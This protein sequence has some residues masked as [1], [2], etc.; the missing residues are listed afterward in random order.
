MTA[1]FKPS[2]LSGKAGAP[3]SK[4][5][6]HRLLLLS[7]LSGGK[8]LIK[9]LGTSEDVSAMT[10]CLTALGAKITRNG[11]ETTVDSAGF[12][13]TV[14][15]SLYCRESGN[16]L[17][18]LIPLCLT[19]EKTVSLRGSKRLMERPQSVYREL[20][21]KEGFMYN[22]DG[23]S[24]TVR[25]SLKPGKYALD[26]S[27]SSQFI[28][29]MIFALLSLPGESEIKII[30]PF[31]SRSYIDL[32]LSAVEKFGGRAYFEDDLTVKVVGRSLRPADVTC[33]GDYSNAA[34]LDAF[35][36]IG[37]DVTLC[38]LDPDSKQGDRVYKS[39]FAAFS[40]GT[41]TLNITDCPD[42]GPVLMALGCAKSGCKL[43]GT[44][45]LAMKE[46]DRGEAMEKEL[47]KL[48][49]RLDRRENEIEVFG[50]GLHAPTEP[51]YG[52]NDHRIVMS[53]SLLLSLTGGEI[54][55]CEAVSK[56]FP[57]FFEAIARLGCDV[58]IKD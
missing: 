1:V 43:T 6:S 4:S 11:D 58:K 16:T 8:C 38:G 31:E 50:G 45:R 46:S 56:T 49:C 52:H 36:L 21:E 26:G 48:G 18:F 30:P 12:L 3:P 23:E 27:V 2:R 34:F 57:D 39:Y 25:G 29:G 9:N 37:G 35:N 41:P 32:T 5:M 19:T 42:L 13:K 51:L 44:R 22:S 10:D 33:E 28:S 54:T 15:E 14:P 24:I 7:A 53:L 55:G 17:R 20:C 47:S 40:E